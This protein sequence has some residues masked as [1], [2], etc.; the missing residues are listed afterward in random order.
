MSAARFAREIERR[1]H[2]LHGSGVVLS[3][4]DWEVLRG[5]YDLGVPLELVDEA[6]AAVSESKRRKP[7]ASLSRLDAGVRA[8]WDT[9]RAGRFETS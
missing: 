6:F 2:H 5:W 9:V 8:A 3:P 4:R 7:P 1:W